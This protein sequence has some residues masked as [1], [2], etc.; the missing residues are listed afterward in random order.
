MS[1]LDL[2]RPRK[3]YRYAQQASLERA[4]SHGEFRLAAADTAGFLTL[5]F[6]SVWDERLFDDFSAANI[7]LVIHDPEIFGERLHRAVQRLLPNWAG[8]DAAVSYGAGS[9]LGAAFTKD[10]SLARQK[11]W[12]FAWRPMQAR[13]SANPVVVEIGSIENIAELRARAS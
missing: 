13:M 7:G 1:S 6:S 12:L 11:E 9:P 5:S 4:L 10:K 3:L 8:I 2:P